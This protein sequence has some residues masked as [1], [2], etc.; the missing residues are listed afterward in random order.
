LE[1]DFEKRNETVRLELPLGE[2]INP[3]NDN[4]ITPNEGLDQP[5]FDSLKNDVF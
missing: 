2:K 4:E 1:D 5:V 3:N